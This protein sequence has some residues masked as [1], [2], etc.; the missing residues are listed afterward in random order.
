M[1][2]C[3]SPQDA[4]EK[5]K[6]IYAGQ[7][8]QIRQRFEVYATGESMDD[9]VD[10]GVYPMLAVSVPRRQV[11]QTSMLS[12]G[13]IAGE[14]LHAITVTRPDLF[15]DYLLEQL[16]YVEQRFDVS[17]FVGISDVPIPL[18]FAL[19][20]ATAR[21]TG[22]QKEGLQY[23]FHLPNL[24]ATNDDIVDGR[25]ILQR[26]GPL[27][28]SLFTAERVD[29][30]LHR[31][32]HYT[33]TDPEHFQPFILFTNYQRYVSEFIETGLEQV[34]AGNAEMLVEPGG[35]ITY[36]DGCPSCDEIAK[37]P[38]MPAYHLVRNNGQGVTLVNI[39]VGPSNAKNITDHLAVLRPHAWLMIGHC[40]ALRRSQ[41]LG[42]YVLAHAY[43]RDDNVLDHVLPPSI[44]LPNIAEVQ[45]ALTQSVLDETGLNRRELKKHLRTG[46]VVTTDDR[47]WELEFEN[48][49]T[50]LNQARAIAIDM[51]S[52]TIAANGYR[53]R[54]PYGTLLCASDRPLHGE[55]KLP[56]MAD[57]FYQERVGQHLKI[58]LRTVNY[59]AEEVKNGTLHSR[60]L[61]SFD[62][63]LF[64]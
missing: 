4:V 14:T 61:R 43:L 37:M 62:E 26:S 47:N 2:K 46:T 10:N 38:Q 60:K 39:G 40:G 27:P 49:A 15:S 57:A 33:A 16:A 18:T 21:L 12:M 5:L 22:N 1:T 8:E 20:Q 56:G 30:S 64:R 58:G 36:A 53:Y 34:K 51:E 52:A 25:K 35:R 55:I 29:Y 32:Q 19:E 59:L 31:I 41:S 3:A 13:R 54:V 17:I 48:I 9:A 6:A 24:A 28:L 7:L 42:D 50:R 63:P 45:L 23:F 11:R 44:P